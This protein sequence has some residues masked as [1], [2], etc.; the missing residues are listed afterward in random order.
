LGTQEQMENQK[1]RPIDVVYVLG[2]GS[3]WKNNELRFSLRA[4]EKNL[5]E[6]RK[7]WIVGEKPDWIKGINHIPFK[8]ELVNNADGN[9]AR[10]VLRVCQEKGLT[11]KF[12]FINDDHLV[13]KP[14]NAIDIP[15]FHKGDM[16]TFSNEYFETD[17]WRGRLWRTK[18]IL[19]Q[20]GFT[21]F[22]YDCH[23]PMVMSKKLFPVVMSQFNFEKNIGFTM[24][25][26]YGNVVYKESGTRLKG[27]KITVFKPMTYDQVKEHCVGHKFVAFNDKGLRPGMKRWMYNN[28]PD[29]SSFEKED[30]KKEPYMEILEWLSSEDKNYTAGSMLFDKYGKSK[31]VKKFFSRE[32]NSGRREKL[33]HQLRELLN[34][35]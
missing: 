31:K 18:N 12:L 14:V 28:F 4:L 24:K 16:A 20:K 3:S 23:V 30:M 32:E 7:I 26:L 10:K 5:K 8:D 35:L 9:I 27:E 1:T 25:S 33:E 19:I 34:Y 15:A 2:T 21:A 11:E 22:H 6:F 29:P 13:M 17:F